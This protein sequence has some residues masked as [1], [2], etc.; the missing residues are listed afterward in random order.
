[1]SIVQ[2]A[3]LVRSKGRGE[4]TVLIHMTPGEVKGLQAIALAHGGSLTIN[5]ETGLPEAGF[6]KKLLPA[7]AGAALMM[8]PGTQALGAPMIAGLVG[9]GSTALGLAKGKSFGDALGSGLKAGLGAYG[10]ASLTGGIQGAMKSAVP[11]TVPSTVPGT[12]AVLK[13]GVK[14]LGSQGFGSVGSQGFVGSDSALNA[15]TPGSLQEA[16]TSSAIPATQQGLTAAADPSMLSRFTTGFTDTA[17]KGLGG[18]PGNKF[19]TKAAPYVAGAGVLSSLGAFDQPETQFPGLPQQPAYEGPYMPQPREVAFRSQEGVPMSDTS[20]FQYFRPVSYLPEQLQKLTAADGGEIGMRDGDFVLDART[21]SEIGN[22]SSNAGKEVL[23]S[24]G[25]IPVDGRGDGVSDSVR[26]N[27]GGVQQARVARDEVIIPRD[28]V[29][30][31][32]GPGKLYSLM[33]RAREAR[34]VADRGEDTGLAR[35]LM[36]V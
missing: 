7:I 25:G 27:I 34:R 26:A 21:V 22:G 24:M 17:R 29:Q 30:D 8:I 2:A 28:R 10:G 15:I 1:M 9:G 16:L 12:E 3:E 18:L 32:G 33:D 31:M 35:G 13:E 5:P 11:S 14:N 19:L 23:A 36:A 20:E 4:D 6:L